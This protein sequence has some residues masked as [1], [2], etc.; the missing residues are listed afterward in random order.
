MNQTEMLDL[1]DKELRKNLQSPG[2]RREETEHVV[3]HVSL[4]G[5][6]GFI[7]SSNVNEEN[8]KRVIQEEM[9]YFRQ[10]GVGF[11]WKVYS[12]DK[13]ENLVELLEQ[14]NFAVEPREALMVMEIKENHP[15]VSWS[16]S[17]HLREIVDEKGIREMIALIDF[18]W[19]DSHEELG[20]R[21]W[22]DKQHDPESLY[23]YGIYDGDRLVSAAWMYFED[24]SSFASLWGGST[25][26][27]YRGRGYYTELLAVR[28]KKAFE[29]GYPFLTVD[30]RPTSQP[31]LEKHGFWRLAY[32]Y[33]CQSPELE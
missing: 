30:A 15:F 2:S 20:N 4:N 18:I 33:G 32:C 16:V 24:N 13:P 21:L 28:A 12:Y 25:L 6:R 10:L 19:N 1:F 11:E 8:A 29:R 26:P 31:I 5:E 17:S 27:D 3:R 14:E 9:D 22:R 23:I 7:I